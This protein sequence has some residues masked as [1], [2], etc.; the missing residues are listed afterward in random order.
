MTDARPPTLCVGWL[1]DGATELFEV[2]VVGFHRLHLLAA[3]GDKEDEQ[4]VVGAKI[5][6]H[7]DE[8]RSMI[9]RKYLVDVPAF[10]LK[11]NE[12][13]ETAFD[14]VYVGPVR[15]VRSSA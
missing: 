7:G 14:T 13:V 6:N 15:L 10:C 3:R 12:L 8:L 1:P 4:Q 11:L 9:G 5:R 2:N